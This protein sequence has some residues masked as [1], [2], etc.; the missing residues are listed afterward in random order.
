MV[1]KQPICAITGAASGIGQALMFSFAN[2]GYKLIGIDSDSK[3]S[4]QVAKELKRN[5]AECKFIISDLSD[6]ANLN[7]IIANLPVVNV[8]VHCAG[9]SAV[10]YFEELD[11]NEQ[12]KVLDVNLLAPMLLT[13]KLLAEKRLAAGSSLVFI[14]SLSHFV[15]YPSAV[16][17]AASKRGLASYARSLRVALVSKDIHVLSVYPGPTRTPHARKYSPDNS[18][19][20]L[21]MLPEK[22]AQSILHAINKKNRI[23]IIGI[24]NKV[25]A[26]L[27]FAFPRLTEMIMRRIMLNLEKP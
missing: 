26:T 20:H 14:S 11:I 25:F 4:K 1:S 24:A 12:V 17:Y 2:E 27:G 8:F 15:G 6:Q 3:G 23:L 5:K 10:G 18:R 19:E 9:I 16:T 22:V 13:K 21:R 7:H